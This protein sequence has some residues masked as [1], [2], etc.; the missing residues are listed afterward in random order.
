MECVCGHRVPT[1]IV[2]G[3]NDKNDSVQT[4]RPLLQYMKLNQVS[5]V[6]QQTGGCDALQ[7][8]AYSQPKQQPVLKPLDVLMSI[9]GP[10]REK[11]RNTQ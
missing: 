2:T 11:K 5:F 3:P 1:F 7:S 6:R 10:G 8:K 9:Y 4:G